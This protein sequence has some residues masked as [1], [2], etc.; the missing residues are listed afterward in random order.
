MNEGDFGR[1]EQ[2]SKS[3]NTSVQGLVDAGII[4]QRPNKVRLV[5]R[6]ELPPAWDPATDGRLT[7]WEV[8]QQLIRRLGDDGESAAADLL[9]R[10]GSGLGETAK[11]LAYRL[12]LICERKGWAKE[13]LSYNALVTSW[14]ELTRLAAAGPLAES[15]PTLFPE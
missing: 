9:R 10:A 11:E 8:T 5:A 6:D 2:L 14:P 1:A 3:R 4:S 12:Y 15:A 7:V 13:A